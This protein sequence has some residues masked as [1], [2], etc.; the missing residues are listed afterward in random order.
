MVQ[1]GREPLL[2]MP[3]ANVLFIPEASHIMKDT[4]AGHLDIPE[5]WLKGEIQVIEPIMQVVQ[6]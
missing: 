4:P 2:I 3:G 1:T 6:A 5:E